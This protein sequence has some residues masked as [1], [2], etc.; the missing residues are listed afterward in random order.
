MSSRR[1]IL[2]ARRDNIARCTIDE[3][4]NVAMKMH[5]RIGMCRDDGDQE[6]YDAAVELL[7]DILAAIRE[8]VSKG[9]AI[10]APEAIRNQLSAWGRR[11]GEASA[12]KMSK[13]ALR[14]N[15]M[16]GHA[17]RWER[18]QAITATE[19]RAMAAACGSVK[20]AAKELSI[21]YETARRRLKNEPELKLAI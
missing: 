20:A 3:L 12:K 14:M 5:I 11:G 13:A 19:I 15:G 7:G 8:R 2:E 18:Q 17:K 1:Q 9:E 21:G 10:N 4:W 16:K 6:D